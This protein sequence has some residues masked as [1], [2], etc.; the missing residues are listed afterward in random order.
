MK[1]KYKLNK[2]SDMAMSSR[3]HSHVFVSILEFEEMDKPRQI[4]PS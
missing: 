2:V 4:T 3:I 1:M